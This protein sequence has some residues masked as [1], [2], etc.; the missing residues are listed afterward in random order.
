MEHDIGSIISTELDKSGRKTKVTVR[1]Y[2]KGVDF[3][4]RSQARRILYGMDK[5]KTIILDFIKV[6]GIGQGFADEIFRVFKL[7][8]PGVEILV[9]NASKTVMF[10]INRAK[11]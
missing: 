11:L 1:L 4:S 8:H 3:V 5:F 6:K 10:M 2:E 9:K 7:E